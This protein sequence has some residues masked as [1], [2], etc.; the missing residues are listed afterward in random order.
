VPEDNVSDLVKCGFMSECSKRIYSDFATVRKAL[1]VAA[2]KG[3]QRSFAEAAIA[4]LGTRAGCSYTLTFD[5]KALRLPGFE[6]P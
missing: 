6:F 2:L 1:N 3:G 5:Q 4:A